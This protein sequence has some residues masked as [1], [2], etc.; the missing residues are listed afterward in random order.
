MLRQPLENGQVTISRAHSTV[1][2][3]AKFILLAEMNP[4]PCGYAGAIDKYCT[5]S[6]QQIRSYQNRV[7][8]PILDRIN[9]LLTLVPEKLNRSMSGEETSETI[10][11]RVMKARKIQFA[12]YGRSI[13]NAR[14][15]FKELIQSSPLTSK[16]QEF[17]QTISA[18]EALSNRV[19]IK[20]IRVA[21]TISDLNEEERISDL[22]L[23]EALS[24]RK[25]SGRL[26]N[27]RE[28]LLS[29]KKDRETYAK[30]SEEK[31]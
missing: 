8:G 28:L 6:T 16:Q 2:Y 10:R 7:S 19:Q 21:R 5:C 23:E 30:T 17:L 1:T 20:M 27:Q 31:E 15:A 11:M 3:P 26:T 22:A 29:E 18:K 4:C 13:S 25:V 9:I 14:V 12:R 24:Y